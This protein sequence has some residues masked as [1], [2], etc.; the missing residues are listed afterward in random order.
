MKL[1]IL[2]FVALTMNAFAQPQLYEGND[3]FDA[4]KYHS[5][6]PIYKRAFTKKATFEAAYKLGLSYQNI[7]ESIEAENWLTRAIEI[8]TS[9]ADCFLA[10]GNA[11][12]ENGK[13]AA[14]KYHFQRAASMDV[15]LQISLRKKIAFCDSSIVW[16]KLSSVNDIQS[17]KYGNTANSE[18]SPIFYK[19]AIYFSSDRSEIDKERKEMNQETGSAYLGIFTASLVDSGF[20]DI[21]PVVIGTEPFLYHEATCSFATKSDT[22]YF[23]SVRKDDL[24]PDKLNELDIYL[25]LIHI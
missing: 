22:L 11:L 23:S 17:L 9:S 18:F 12:K 6:I 21:A 14:A 2:L 16:N 24:I 8:D 15:N 7:G 1:L 25:S 4:Q 13:Y 20:H 5:A 3:L 10:L 19:N